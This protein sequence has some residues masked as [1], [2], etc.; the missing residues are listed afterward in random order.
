M[1]Q[2]A[3]RRL[4]DAEDALDYALRW[5]DLVGIAKAQQQIQELQVEVKA[6]RIEYLKGQ[7]REMFGYL[8]PQ[9]Q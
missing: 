8:K 5:H 7:L 3:Q 1:E 6:E 2:T 4:I 9:Q